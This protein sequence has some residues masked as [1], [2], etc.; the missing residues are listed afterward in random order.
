MDYRNTTLTIGQLQDLNLDLVEPSPVEVAEEGGSLPMGE[1]LYCD[2]RYRLVGYGGSGGQGTVYRARR[3][4]ADGFESTVAIKFY[5]PPSNS[6][7]ADYHKE[8]QRIARNATQIS[9]IQHDNLL[10]IQ[11]FVQL[12][13]TR[14]MLMEWIEGADLDRL[15]E[16]KQIENLRRNLSGE[17]WNCLNEVVL[18]CGED[19]AA[20][21]PGVAIAIIHGCLLGLA[22]LHRHGIFHC[23]LKPS[24]IMIKRTGAV[25]LIDMDSSTSNA[26]GEHCTRLT[27]YFMAP[28]LFHGT[29]ATPQTDIASLGYTAIEMLTG[30]HIFRDCRSLPELERAKL[31]LPDRLEGILFSLQRWDP[32]LLEFCRAMIAVNP[33]ERF[34][35]AS[36]AARSASGAASF[37]RE[38]VKANLWADYEA[39][40][41]NWIELATGRI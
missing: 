41:S 6:P 8:M 11:D 38:L 34:A 23:D 3:E 7:V 36:V 39:E 10:N 14:A 16:L 30:R 27:P 28:E 33:Q 1:N 2:S 40:L 37:L 25:K 17:Q 29:R 12:G 20:L 13:T 19:R 18:M 35:D 15:L 21:K 32:R 9:D 22:T 24:N 5:L 31:E 26:G 4:G